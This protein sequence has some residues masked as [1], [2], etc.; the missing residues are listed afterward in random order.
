MSALDLVVA[1]SGLTLSAIGLLAAFAFAA[2]WTPG[3]NNMMLASS[4]ATYGFRR[5]VPH[6]LGVA[7]GFPVMFFAVALGADSA[8]AFIETELV[9]VHPAFAHARDAFTLLA[10]AVLVWFGLRIALS[11]RTKKT[12]GGAE[13]LTGRPFSFIE[14]AAFQWIN[15]KAWAMAIGAA[16]LYLQEV[17]PLTKAA[18]GACVFLLSGLTS[19]HSWAAF[20]VVIRRALNTPTRLRAFNVA[21]GVLIIGSV[22]F[23]FAG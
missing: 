13:E 18:V 8:L 6:A 23:L 14:A 5:T 22:G 19:A 2:T 9:A 15:P 21:M 16:T 7:F 1:N 17:E 20:G 11:G 3:P 4:G 10:A 12:E